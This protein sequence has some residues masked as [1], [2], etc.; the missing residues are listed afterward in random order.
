MDP[1]G[2][3]IAVGLTREHA[4]SA[5]PDAPVVPDRPRRTNRPPRTFGLRQN[6]ATTL[7]TIAGWVEPKHEADCQPALH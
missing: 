1:V 5:M 4:W 3:V 2:Y 6:A 7:R